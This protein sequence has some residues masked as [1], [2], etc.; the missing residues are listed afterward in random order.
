M[1]TSTPGS[2]TGGGSPKTGG[3]STSTSV[4]SFTPKQTACS[5]INAGAIRPKIKQE[6][7]E[8]LLSKAYDTYHASDVKTLTTTF[9]LVT[10]TSNEDNDKELSST[11]KINMTLQQFQR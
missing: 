2:T 6:D 4:P 10:A 9:N 1:S 7:H 8:S 5:T 3:R 11:Y